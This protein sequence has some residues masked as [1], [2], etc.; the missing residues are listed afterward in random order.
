MTETLPGRATAA[1]SLSAT[2]LLCRWVVRQAAA[3]E[4]WF[5]TALDHLQTSADERTLHLFLGQ[6]PRRLG[7]ADLELTP[8]DLTAAHALLP[9][10]SPLDWSLDGAARIAGLLTFHGPRPFAALFED[11]VR[12]ADARELI[13]L[14][15]GLSFYPEPAAL[16]AQVGAGLRSNIRAVFEAIAHGNPYP[17]DH[18][19]LHRWNHMV[20]K[21]LFIGSRLAPIVGIDQRN[22][23]ELARILL[24]YADERWAAGRAVTPELWRCVGPC[25]DA[26]GAYAALQRAMA[27]SPAER[28]AAGLALSQTDTPSARHLLASAPETAALIDTG[29]VGWG[30]FHHYEAI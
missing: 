20:L 25:V 7:K 27:G 15:R 18:F 29:R 11:L 22:N 10:W 17:R 1:S 13:T 26:L 9:G 12:T 21:A 28:L 5:I 14:Y 3:Q 16:S 8:Q 19:D 2:A 23:P 6:V 4:T 30:N 24:D